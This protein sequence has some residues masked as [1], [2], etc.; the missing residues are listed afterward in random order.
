[1]KMLRAIEFLFP[2]R[3]DKGAGTSASAISPLLPQT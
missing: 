3:R 2:R 1:M